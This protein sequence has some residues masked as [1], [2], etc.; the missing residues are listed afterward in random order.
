MQPF[1]FRFEYSPIVALFSR[2]DFGPVFSRPFPTHLF[3]CHQILFPNPSHYLVALVLPIPFRRLFFLLCLQQFVISLTSVASVFSLIPSPYLIFHLLK[4]S[5][6]SSCTRAHS[7]LLSR[8]NDLASARP[9]RSTWQRSIG[10][11][12]SPGAPYLFTSQQSK[13][14]PPLFRGILHSRW[15][16]I[17]LVEICKSVFKIFQKFWVVLSR[18]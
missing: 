14:T 10:D 3:P 8:H 9:A 4:S 18:F 12:L 2:I 17:L 7:S 5:A 15:K 11:Q 13:L 16:L 1:C 6:S